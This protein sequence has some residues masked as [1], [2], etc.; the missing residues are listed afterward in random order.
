MDERRPTRTR[1]EKQPKGPSPR[2]PRRGL[3]ALLY[4]AFTLVFG[5]VSTVLWIF[6]GPFTNLK[7]YIIESVDQTRHAYLLRPMSLFLVSEATIKKYAL[8]EN[9]SGPTI[10]IQDIQRRDFSH[11]NDPT[12]QM[13][14][15]HEPTFN[16]FILLVKDPKRIRV[17]ATK[18]LH[19]RGETVMQM[20]QDSGAIAG[21][22][23]GGFVDTNWQG[24]GAYPQG[25]TITDGK[26]VSMTG[27][28]SQ[29]QPVIAF[30]KEG[31]MIAGTYSLNQLRSLDVWQCVG[32]GPVLVE[33]GKPTV[34]AENYA[35]NPRTAIGQTKDGT[36]ILLVT[37]GRYATG[38]NDVGASFADVARIMLQFH[39]DI[40]ANLDGGS[41]A[42]FV[43]KGR[44]W[45]RPVDILGARAVATSIVVMPEGGGKRG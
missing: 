11:I 45:N 27:S 9:L 1:R 38:P 25:I 4:V 6:E 30:T 29:P 17:V 10:P 37:D 36:V 28:P 20:V 5:Y 26:L 14:T 12:V 13:I 15:L 16:A 2:K 8:P 33:N 32:F 18:Y 24:T 44:M 7:K 3:R 39:A 34:S 42:T 40:A 21:I 43:Y 23:A 35:V 31:Q 22:N 41:S 19:V